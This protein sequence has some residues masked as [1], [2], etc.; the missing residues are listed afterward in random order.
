MIQEVQGSVNTLREEQKKIRSS[1]NAMQGSVNTLPCSVSAMQEEQSRVREEQNTLL[2]SVFDVSR[3]PCQKRRRRP[4]TPAALA[5][6]CG[7][8][9]DAAAESRLAA[10]LLDEVRVGGWPGGCEAVAQ[11]AAS[12]RGLLPC[13]AALL[14]VPPGCRASP[15]CPLS[16][17]LPAALQHAAA[18]QFRKLL[19]RVLCKQ[20]KDSEAKQASAG[21]CFAAA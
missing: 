11:Q 12:G 7:L 6:D 18:H 4:Y 17:L 9:H 14:L 10:K 5:S 21:P 8:A 3:L 19:M 1:V 20:A 16:P 2:G 13:A 15:V